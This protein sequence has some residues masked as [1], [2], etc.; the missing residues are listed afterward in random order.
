MKYL[1]YL[2]IYRSRTDA[3]CNECGDIVEDKLADHY[4]KVHGKEPKF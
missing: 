1:F 4:V 2:L 3:Y